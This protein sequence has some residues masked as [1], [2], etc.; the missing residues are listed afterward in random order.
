V[1]ATFDSGQQAG[2][3]QVVAL[4]TD[5][6]YMWFFSSANVEV[7]IKVLDGCGLGDHYWVFAGGL[8]NV[9][10]VMTV[11]DTQTGV[12]KIYTNPPS[13]SFQPI[14]DVAAFAA[15]P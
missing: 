4:T 15:C 3:A 9:K 8:T 6:A 13:T 7:L 10:V 1:E 5:T 12:R 14:Q 11:T 2:Q